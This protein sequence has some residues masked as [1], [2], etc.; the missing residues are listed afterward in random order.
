M[1]FEQAA[2]RI[3]KAEEFG[4]LQAVVDEAL[5]PKSVKR[6]LK[7][8]RRGGMRIR[9]FEQILA[10][11]TLEDSVG[12]RDVDGKQ[13]YAALTVSDQAQMRELYLSKLETVDVSLRHEFKKLYQYY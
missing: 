9:D 13:L 5:S 11:R 3:E 6:F 2:I 7:R 12:R 10:A 4:R 1:N 8:L